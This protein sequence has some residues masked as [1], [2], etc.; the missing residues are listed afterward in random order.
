ML[1]CSLHTFLGTGDLSVN[2]I[3][4]ILGLLGKSNILGEMESKQTIIIDVI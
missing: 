2:D 1:L 4:K 3:N